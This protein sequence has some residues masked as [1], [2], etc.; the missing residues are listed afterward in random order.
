MLVVQGNGAK[1]QA[2][3]RS[4]Q[5]G[6]YDSG[7]AVTVQLHCRSRN[8][9]NKCRLLDVATH[10]QDIKLLIHKHKTV[11]NDQSRDTRCTIL[12]SKILK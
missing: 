2:T 9:G 1:S 11:G 10:Y 4:I 12:Q 7:T 6:G 3:V 5:T 8:N